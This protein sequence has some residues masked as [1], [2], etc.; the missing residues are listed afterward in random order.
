M[1]LASEGCFAWDSSHA[2]SMMVTFVVG[3]AS[4]LLAQLA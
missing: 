3:F 1:C 4:I 2:A